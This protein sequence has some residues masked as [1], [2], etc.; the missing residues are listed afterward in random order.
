ML[1]KKSYSYNGSTDDLS[2]G[3][4]WFVISRQN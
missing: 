1:K 2:V 4:L 3:S